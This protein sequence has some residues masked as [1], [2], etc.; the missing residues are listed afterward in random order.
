MRD[1]VKIAIIDNG[2]RL[3]HPAFAGTLPVLVDVSGAASNEWTG[4]GTAIYN[5]IRKAGDIADIINFR[6]V[7]SGEGV[8]EMGLLEILRTIHLDYP[9]DTLSTSAL[10]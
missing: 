4:H 9:V 6:L 8:E 5:I 1:K 3:D 7:S 10:V 2:V